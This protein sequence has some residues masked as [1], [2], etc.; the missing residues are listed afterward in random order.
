MFG[1]RQVVVCGY[2]EV[3]CFTLYKVHLVTCMRLLKLMNCFSTF[4]SFYVFYAFLVFKMATTIHDS[5]SL[6]AVVG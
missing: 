5:Q 1:G 3:R 6:S 4:P 2:G